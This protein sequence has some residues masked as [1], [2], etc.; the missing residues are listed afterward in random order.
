MREVSGLDNKNPV[1]DG[2]IVRLTV[3]ETATQSTIDDLAEWLVNC[4]T[5]GD[6]EG[7][8]RRIQ[9]GSE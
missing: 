9:S 7:Y 2:R 5:R 3:D 1:I 8:V 4:I 6:Y